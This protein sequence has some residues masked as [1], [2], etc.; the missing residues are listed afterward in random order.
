MRFSSS[1]VAS[2][3]AQEIGEAL[4]GNTTSEKGPSRRRFARK[5]R[6]DEA[7]VDD[8]NNE[9]GEARNEKDWT[10]ALF[11]RTSKEVVE[12]RDAAN[13]T[14]LP[15]LFQFSSKEDVARESSPRSA[16]AS[17][18]FQ[19]KS[20]EKECTSSALP[21]MFQFSSKEEEVRESAPRS[22]VHSAVFQRK[23]K[24][25]EKEFTSTSLPTLFQL[26]SNEGNVQESTPRRKGKDNDKECTGSSLPAVFQFSS[27]EEE[28]NDSSSRKVVP[29]LFK[30]KSKDNEEDVV[31]VEEVRENA[32]GSRNH[33]LSAKLFPKAERK[34][35]KVTYHNFSADAANVVKVEQDEAVPTLA[36]S[37][38][39][40]IKVQVGACIESFILRA[41]Y[42][43]DMR[44]PVL[45]GNQFLH[46]RIS[47]PLLQAST[48]TLNDCLLRRGFDFNVF[49]PLGLP[50]T[51]GY[52]VVGNILEVG[53]NVAEFA[54]GERV[55]AL[56]RSGGNAR[57]VSVPASSL[58]KVPSNLDSA[59][60]AAL[61]SIYTTAYQALRKISN[62]GPMFSLEGKKILI[63]GGMDGV[64]QALIQM[65]KK[66]R[67]TIYATA[68]TVRHIYIK[69]VLGVNPLP[70]ADWLSSVEGQLDY[71]FDG[72]CEDG[73]EKSF[74][75][76][77]PDGEM[78]CYGHASMLKERE[79]GI[80]GAPFSAR[81]NQLYTQMSRRVHT[82]DI[83][84]SFQYDPVVYKQ[85]LKSLC[86]L[87]KW[88]KLK[89]HIAKRVSLPEVAAAQT[90]LEK[91]DIRGTIVCFPW[92]PIRAGKIQET[93][94]ES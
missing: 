21:T 13:Q 14:A 15:A 76:L 87:L 62:G 31:K 92:R 47:P 22:S 52:D 41:L 17:S 8:S 29:A 36:S 56:V 30:R 57:F 10:P 53:S 2:K 74:K 68:P 75:A 16:A 20:K 38:H 11:K 46:I 60:V 23:G 9:G 6:S 58:V 77:K 24:S 89:P 72:V 40:L 63:L 66:A 27:K 91:G 82:V 93:E 48:V 69:S 80:L 90:K 44:S 3:E 49:S 67:A 18:I 81:M 28:V 84:E 88:N 70:E 94:E 7:I 37:Y 5:K 12:E 26:N 79:I 25:K 54:V 64:G 43:S 42:L 32:S 39:V 55:A 4:S 45:C 51:P 65:C 1:R 59:E 19:R 83:W 85:D 33:A 78:V 61:V 73:T 35:I 50:L 34:Q 71:V 86:Q